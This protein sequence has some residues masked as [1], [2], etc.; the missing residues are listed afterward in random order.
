MGLVKGTNCGFVSSAPTSDPTSPSS[1][2]CHNLSTGGKFVSPATAIKVTEIGWYCGNNGG[3]DCNWEAGIYDHNSGDDNPENLLDGASQTNAKGTGTGWKVATGLNITISSSTTYWLAI[4]VDNEYAKI[5]YLGTVG[6]KED[7]L[8]PSTTF[9]NP[10]G[11][12]SFTNAALVAIYA[13]WEAAPGVPP[14]TSI[15]IG[16]EWKTISGTAVVKVNIGD[17]WKT[18]T[19][20]KINIGD[21]WKAVTIA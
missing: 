10:W 2:N 19:A 16:D 8:W 18:V 3:T 14:F 17:A 11:T 20:A 4:Q 5:D 15:N 9:A 1:I 7:Q 6:E 12:T 13:V 21:A